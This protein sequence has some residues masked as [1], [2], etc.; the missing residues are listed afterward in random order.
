M[1]EIYFRVRWPHGEIQ[2]CYSPST[3]IE[4]FSSSGTAAA[5]TC[6]PGATLTVEVLLAADGGER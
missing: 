3:V 1:P 4:E 2:R 6:V 5:Y